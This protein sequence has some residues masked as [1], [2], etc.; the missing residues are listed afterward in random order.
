MTDEEAQLIK[1]T[2]YFDIIDT[3]LSKIVSNFRQSETYVLSKDDWDI[4]SEH[5]RGLN[6][7]ALQYHDLKKK[8]DLG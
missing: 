3:V 7:I 5:I 6:E 4:L 8:T 2:R 1:C